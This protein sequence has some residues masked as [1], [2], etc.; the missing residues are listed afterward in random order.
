M[1]KHFGIPYQGSKDRIALDIHRQLPSG[2]RFVDL[3]GGGFAMSHA[4]LLIK[5]KY[6]KVLY[7]EINPLLIDLIRRAVD[8]YYDYA[9]FTPEWI[10]REDFERLKE[11]DGYV[12]YIWSFGNG[13]DAYLY[14]KDIEEYKHQGH[15]YCI[16]GKPIDG[17][18]VKGDNPKARRLNL[19]KFKLYTGRDIQLERLE[20]L[21]QLQHLCQ[22]ERLDALQITCAD[23]R[24][25]QYRDGDVVYL[26]PPY[27]GTAG[28]NEEGFDHKAFYDW[29]ASRPY[30]VW[31][32]SYKISDDRFKLVWAKRLRGTFAGAQDNYNFE[33]LYTNTD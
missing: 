22:L 23:Y 9:N 5:G 29:C 19:K 16:Y 27:E 13:G 20:R 31:F 30:Q 8:G 15:D 33:C 18:P 26:D 1:A 11:A 10:S 6:G 25:Y 32:S 17:I 28:Y 24:D 21:Q 12:K 3:F 2:D 4:A 14:G 7:N